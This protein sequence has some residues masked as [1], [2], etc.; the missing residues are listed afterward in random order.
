MRQKLKAGTGTKLTIHTGLATEWAQNGTVKEKWLLTYEII[1][2]HADVLEKK[3][4]CLCDKL[5][6]TC[7]KYKKKRISL[8]DYFY[9]ILL[10]VP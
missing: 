9:F 5:T 1:C 4:S 3:D 7:Y 6:P 10:K 8:K 2:D